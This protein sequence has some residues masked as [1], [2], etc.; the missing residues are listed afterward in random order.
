MRR[1][2]RCD[3]AGP[4]LIQFMNM[5]RLLTK[6]KA[7]AS[8]TK[9]AFWIGILCR[10]QFVCVLPSSGRR[11]NVGGPSS[12]AGADCPLPADGAFGSLV[13]VLGELGLFEPPLF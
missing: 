4:I 3:F 2:T 6:S 11:F 5:S 12:S 10:V 7:P 13:V 9:R 8:I 1:I